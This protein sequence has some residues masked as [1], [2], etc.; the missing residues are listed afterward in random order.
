[1]RDVGAEVGLLRTITNH[2]QQ[3]WLQYDDLFRA[4]HTSLGFQTRRYYSSWRL[5]SACEAYSTV[6]SACLHTVVVT[7]SHALR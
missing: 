2:G 4:L 5:G 6:I 7:P 3:E 1:M